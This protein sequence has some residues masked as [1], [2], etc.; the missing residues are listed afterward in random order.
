[1]EPR[2]IQHQS[3]KLVL[4]PQIRQYLKLLQLPIA[5][6]SQA[7]EQELTENP[8]LEE[9]SQSK[10]DEIP[11]TPVPEK[12]AEEK[13]GPE[14]RIGDSFTNLERL[15][16]NFY[17]GEYGEAS[18]DA[19]RDMQKKRD[20]QESLLTK[21]EALSDFLLWQIRFLNLSE[22]ETAIAQEII[23]NL[24]EDG[25]LRA[26]PEEIAKS[27]GTATDAVG[28]MLA[29]IQRLEPPGIG[30]RTLQEALTLQ[31]ERKGPEASLAHKIVTEHLSLLEKRDWPH[32]AKILAVAP[33]EIKSAVALITKLEPKPGRTFYAAEPIAVIPDAAIVA[34]E[35]D[36][37]E[38]RVE[39]YQENIPELR[40]NSYYRQ[41]L[42]DKRLKPEAKAFLRDKL[43]A[44]VNFLKALSQRK[45]TLRGITDEILKAQPEFFVKGFSH[46]RPLRLKDIASS[47]GIHEST[48]SRA[49]QGKYLATPQGTLPYKSFFSTSIGTADGGTESQ[50]SIM[51]T[52]RHLVAAE[53]PAH[54]LSDED[55][56]SRLKDQGIPI[57]RRTA[58]KYRT[59]LKILPSHLRRNR[60]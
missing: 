48:V 13:I 2:L 34:D 56:V 35:E 7:V 21:P 20:F 37:G 27:C 58:A 19:P 42:R 3:Q 22:Q 12:T 47:L 33:S 46:L 18:G 25:Y 41:M 60:D 28:K 39:I 9:I 29:Q 40:I 10:T 59:L 53:D 6:L 49:I 8:L 44:A 50:K 16:E 36:T 4:S 30:A 45:S 52:I 32:L 55:I 57:A 17:A 54:P 26:T 1:M 51:E 14:V 15:D 23:G 38:W 31:L 11:A 5:E 43:Q 24:D